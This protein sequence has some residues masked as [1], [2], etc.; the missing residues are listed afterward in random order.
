MARGRH[1]SSQKVATQ[2]LMHGQPNDEEENLI[3]QLQVPC[4][5]HGEQKKRQ[6]PTNNIGG[7]NLVPHHALNVAKTTDSG[8]VENSQEEAP[9]PKRQF[10][11]G[12]LA[13]MESIRVEL[14]KWNQHQKHKGNRSCENCGK[15]VLRLNDLKRHIWLHGARQP[16][17]GS[18][19]GFLFRF[20][21]TVTSHRRLFLEEQRPTEGR[22]GRVPKPCKACEKVSTDRTSLRR[23]KENTRGAGLNTW[24]EC[25]QKYKKMLRRA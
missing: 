10:P 22:I 25:S 9:L 12:G 6:K 1:G 11:R 21:S 20:P 24:M 3:L 23:H 4:V 8:R 14:F 18:G 15:R 19:C 17:E 2:A 16:P 13:S 7:K 5:S